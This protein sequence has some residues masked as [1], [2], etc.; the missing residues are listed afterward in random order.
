[1]NAKARAPLVFYLSK[2]AFSNL[3]SGCASALACLI[4]GIALALTVVQLN[5]SK[6]WV[7]YQ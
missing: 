3:D 6:R 4:V 2:Q 1:M 7:T 5:L